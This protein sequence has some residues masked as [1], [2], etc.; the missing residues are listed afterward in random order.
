MK[1]ISFNIGTQE[2]TFLHIAS[3]IFV[4]AGVTLL[5]WF[6]VHANRMISPATFEEDV[7]DEVQVLCSP[8]LLDGVCVAPEE[9]KPALYAVMIE[10]HLDARPQSGLARAAVVYEAPVEANYSRFMAL[11]PHGS[12]ISK[13]GPVRSARPYFLDWVS[14]YGKPMYIHVGGS[15]DALAKLK[16]SNYFDFNEFYRGNYFWRSRDRYAPHNV[17]TSSELL[18][19]GSEEYGNASSTIPDT[20]WNYA[21]VEPCTSACVTTITASFL[22]P[23]YEAVWTYSTS[24]EMYSRYQLGKPHVDQ[25]GTQIS[26][27]TIVVQRVVSRVLDSE[28]RIEMETIGEGEAIVFTKGTKV[29]GKWIKSSREGKTRFYDNRGNE[30]PFTP[31]KIWIEVI[32]QVGDLEYK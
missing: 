31:G 3:G 32:N 28:L 26:A 11:I 20:T 4:I 7:P 30:I 25:D 23:V 8:R 19:Q 6:F 5:G 9:T 13:I 10:N 12:D 15:P 14:E 2:I 16:S 27:D 29:E 18:N 22:P 21:K 1:K 24:T 17:Y